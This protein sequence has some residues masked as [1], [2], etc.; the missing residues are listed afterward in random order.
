MVVEGRDPAAYVAALEA[1]S[2]DADHREEM[3]DKGWARARQF[4]WQRTATQTAE[5]YKTFL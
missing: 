2:E 1:L 4:T 5:V 3:I